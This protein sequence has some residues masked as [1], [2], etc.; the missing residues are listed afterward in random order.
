MIT[1]LELV[2]NLGDEVIEAKCDSLL[3]VNQVNE[4]FK[5]KE[6]QMRSVSTPMNLFGG[7]GTTDEFG[8]TIS[9]AKVNSTSLTWDWRN[10]Y[11]DYLRIG[12]LPSDPKESRALHTK[13]ARFSLIEGALFRIS[14][15]GPLARCLRPG[16]TEYAMREAHKGTY[17]NH[18]G[19]R[20]LV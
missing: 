11:I 16:K 17:G 12:K 9:H 8:G 4:T 20:S 15:F 5:V 19:A 2:K 7:S 14:F 3:D 13:A 18:L 1:G 6:E 10:R